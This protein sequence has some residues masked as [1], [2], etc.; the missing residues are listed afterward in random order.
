[1][2]IIAIV[3][4]AIVIVI[5]IICHYLS[6]S[7]IAFVYQVYERFCQTVRKIC[8]NKGT[9]RYL[10]VGGGRLCFSKRGAAA[11]LKL[12]FLIWFSEYFVH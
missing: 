4:I 10:I 6:L 8:C 12:S 5:V 1:M 11:C 2:V 3:I 7:A 9:L